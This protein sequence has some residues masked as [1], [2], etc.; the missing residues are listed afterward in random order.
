[1]KTQYTAKYDYDPVYEG[2]TIAARVF[3]FT[4]ASG[5]TITS[6]A[7]QIRD[8]ADDSLVKTVSLSVN[9]DGDEVSHA[10]IDTSGWPTKRLVYDLQCTRSDGRVRTYLEGS[11]YIKKAV[12]T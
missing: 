11:V 7:M 12:T 5:A 9:V 6:A 4:I 1:M 3:E 8:P 2:D 10:D